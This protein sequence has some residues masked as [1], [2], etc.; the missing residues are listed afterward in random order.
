MS[1]LSAP[2]P[3]RTG[4]VSPNVWMLMRSMNIDDGLPKWATRDAWVRS[5]RHGGWGRVRDIRAGVITVVG[6]K[7]GEDGRP[8]AEHFTLWPADWQAWVG[9]DPDEGLPE[10]GEAMRTRFERDFE[11]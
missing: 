4:T 8:R 11:P 3:I 5:E 9:Y 1:Q 2:S 7:R 10:F 6:W